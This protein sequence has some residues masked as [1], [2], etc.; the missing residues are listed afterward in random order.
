LQVPADT[1]GQSRTQ[2]Q[3]MALGRKLPF[4]MMVAQTLISRTNGLSWAGSKTCKRYPANTTLVLRL[5]E[6]RG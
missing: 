1:A 5:L 6:M 3:T 2:L 4:W